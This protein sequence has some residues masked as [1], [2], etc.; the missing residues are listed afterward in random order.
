MKIAICG[1][2]DFTLEIKKIADELLKRGF[3]V[4]IPISSKKI[5]RGE[6]SLDE[7]KQEKESGVFA[8]RAIKYD[9][10]RAYWPIISNSS[11]ILVVN[12]DKHNIQNYIGGNTFLEMGFAHILNKPIY[13][14]ND[15]P[16]MIYTD[17]IRAMQP[18]VI[19]GD[20]F[21]IKTDREL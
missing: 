10:I 15:I 9:S 21:K 20:L 17:E 7:I 13:L 19:N 12:F 8:D 11:V 2:L 18:I 1:S 3:E 6:F 14:L 16:T 5:L 4:Q